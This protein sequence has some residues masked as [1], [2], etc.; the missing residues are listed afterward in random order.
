[1]RQVLAAVGQG[2]LMHAYEQLFDPHG[3]TVAQAL[4]SRRDLS[5][6]LGYLNVRNTLLGLMDKRVVPIIN[7]NDVVAVEEVSGRVFGDNDTLAAMVANVVDADL[8][9]MLGVVEG[10]FTADPHLDSQARLIPSVERLSEDM[11]SLAGPALDEHARGGMT[12]KLEAARL[13]MASG[14]DTVIA[15]GRT[16]DAVTR[17]ADGESLG[18]FFPATSTRLESRQ[19]WMVSQ[20]SESDAIVVDQGAARAL[21]S[22]NRSLLPPGVL[23]TQGS[24]E[25]GDI[26]SIVRPDGEQIACGIANYGSEDISKIRR[27]RSSEIADTLGHH[28]GD[29]VVHRNN[30][31]VLS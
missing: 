7:E 26:V 11:E 31:V 17:L 20:V 4:L 22:Q 21:V 9:L 12:T 24:F 30:R 28:Y 25:R 6:R 5:D 23:G 8:L 27:L 3:I 10:L 16:P 15:S 13:A 2:R 14:V 18:T 1:M 29:E 19:R